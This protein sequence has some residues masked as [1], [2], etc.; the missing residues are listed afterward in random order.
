MTLSGAKADAAEH[1]PKPTFLQRFKVFGL[2]LGYVIS[3]AVLIRFNKTMMKKDHFPHA[4]ALSAWHMLVS[5]VLCSALYWIAPSAFPAMASTKGDRLSLLKWFIPIGSCFAVMLFGSN[6]AYSYCSVT[7]LQFMKEGNVMLVFLISVALGLQ[8]IT[9]L[10]F[11]VIIWVIVGSALAISGEIHLSTI[12]FIYQAVSQVAECSRMVMGEMVLSGSR[13][14]DPL[15]YTLFLAPICLIVLVVGNL[16]HFSP[17][18]FVDFAEWWPLLIVNALVA[19]VL[20]IFV[21]AVIKECSAVGFVLTGL[22]KDIA[23]VLFSSIVYHERVTKQQAVAF[24]VTLAGVGYWSLL[25][26]NPEHFVVRLAERIL[27]VPPTATSE[28]MPLVVKKV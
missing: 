8:V 28:K 5:S 11:M 7:F 9:R 18:T 2:C 10:R 4:L 23:I 12:G 1:L 24:V 26:T 20:N 16:I 21:A 17:G 14:L 25:K 13:K 19:F 27:C 6:Q 3:S 15:T 22:T